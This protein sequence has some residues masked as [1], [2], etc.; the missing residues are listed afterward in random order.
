MKCKKTLVNLIYSLQQTP[1][2]AWDS[3]HNE[4][5]GSN[6]LTGYSVQLLEVKHHRH[7]VGEKKTHGLTY[8]LTSHEPHIQNN[9]KTKLFWPLR[10]SFKSKT[11]F[12][13]WNWELSIVKNKSQDDLLQNKILH[14]QKTIRRY[15]RYWLTNI[16]FGNYWYLGFQ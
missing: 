8:I 16:I 9:I 15:D 2:R 4:A 12:L 11:C 7:W 6:Q 13:S 5:G 1:H 10:N 14:R 3:W